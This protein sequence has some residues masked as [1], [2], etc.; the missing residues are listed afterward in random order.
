MDQGRYELKYHI[1]SEV[2]EVL[3][4][5]MAAA[6]PPD[7]HSGPEGYVVSSLYFDDGLQSAY[8]EKLNGVP[9]RE[10]YRIRIYNHRAEVIKLECKRRRH[11]FVYKQA[12]TLTPRQYSRLL[13]GD[14]G[15]LL[16]SGQDLLCRFYTA[17]TTRRLAPA[18]VVE[19]HRLA[20]CGPAGS[21]VTFD[22][23][24]RT[25]GRRHDLFAPVPAMLSAGPKGM[26]VMELKFTHGLP[27]VVAQ[28]LQGQNVVVQSI[29]K[30]ALCAARRMEVAQR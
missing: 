13:E 5:R 8:A 1:T 4:R 10:K 30:Y 3:R 24:L 2:F 9:D 23:F 29:S 15:P 26:V 27:S 12:A 6:L 19:Y 16:Q 17:V 7:A 18:V 25:S 14:A 21:R 11:E 28:L 20:F 22:T